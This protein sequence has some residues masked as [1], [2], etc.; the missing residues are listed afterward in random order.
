[1][2]TPKRGELTRRVLVALVGIPLVLGAL[3]VG[4]AV[5]ATMLAMFAAL[6]AREFYQIARSAGVEAMSLLGIPLAAVMPLLVHGHFVGAINV[7]L[8]L[9][10]LVLLVLL[11]ASLWMR[12]TAGKP[13]EST[14]TTVLAVLYA[15]VTLSYAYALRYFGYAIGDVAGM[16]VVM[17]PV[18]LTW[19]SDTGAY[20]A[21]RLIGGPKLF[22]AVSPAKTIAGSVGG[23]VLTVIIA[24][25]LVRWLLRPYA[26]LAFSPAGLLVFA[27]SISAAA[28]LGD[29]VESL[30]KRSAGVKDSGR[31]FPGHGGVLDRL[32]SL[33]F[34]L[35]L[36][37]VLYG[38]L[39]IPAPR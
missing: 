32:D 23:V 1:V 10:T 38:W 19:A 5:L 29:L 4:D 2:S 12:G 14:G 11:A 37:Y 21:G 34:V 27:I 39:L 3:Y 28:Q 16:L 15:G 36:A 24:E 17:L 25:V 22:P 30:F 31:I 7:S 20:F 8:H 35:P 18:V 6:G 9:F 26:Q 13:I 33:Y